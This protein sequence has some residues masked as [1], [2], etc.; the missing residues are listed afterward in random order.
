MEIA[1]AIER[2]F[3]HLLVERGVSNQTI[4]DYREDLEI[5][6]KDFPEKK[7]TDDFLPSDPNDFM[8]KEGEAG[9]ASTTIA[10]RLSCILHFYRFL[11]EEGIIPDP[12]TKVERPKLAKRLP[13]ILSVQ[14]VDNLLEA[15]DL[16]KPNGV[17]DRA[18]LETMYATGLRVSELCALKLS[19]INAENGIIT[20]LHGKGNKQRSVPLGDFAAEYLKNYIDG[21]RNEN[22]GHK[23]PY[24]FLNKVGNPISRNYFFVQVKKYSQQVGITSFN[25]SPH[26]L[27]HCFATHLLENGAELRAVQEMLG[28][29]TSRHDPNLYPGFQPSAS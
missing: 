18:M 10:R 17:R 22:P 29:A 21:P 5:F 8:L 23:S 16:S 11:A 14:E 6:L 19:S 15:P 13:V 25:V 28:H 9:K 1:D 26:T 2:F 4:A 12:G 27:R 3:Q 20:V 24:V 7:T